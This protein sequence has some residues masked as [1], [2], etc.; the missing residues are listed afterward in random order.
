MSGLLLDF[1]TAKYGLS[2]GKD[3]TLENDD[4]DHEHAFLRIQT[5]F[6]EKLITHNQLTDYWYHSNSLS[7]MNFYDFAH[8]ISLQPNHKQDEDFTVT[9]YI[10][11]PKKITYFQIIHLLRP[12][13]TT[14]HK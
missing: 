9:P 7:G 12:I 3:D 2:I 10:D 6:S 4:P 5:D 14:T 1:I 11:T 8:C 13:I